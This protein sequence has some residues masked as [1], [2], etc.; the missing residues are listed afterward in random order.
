MKG[1]RRASAPRPEAGNDGT[2]E[3]R[4][5]GRRQGGDQPP[6]RANYTFLVF[7]VKGRFA[8]EGA[9]GYA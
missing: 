7:F 8:V 3:G 2:P 6:Y 4:E 5:G 9:I 1:P